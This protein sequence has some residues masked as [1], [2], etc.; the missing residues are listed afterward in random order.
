M[1]LKRHRR[2]L[3]STSEAERALS[4]RSP[5]KKTA[6]GPLLEFFGGRVLGRGLAVEGGA[7]V[8]GGV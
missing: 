1:E 5:R 4:W 2:R 8:W 3:Y 6:S 7:G